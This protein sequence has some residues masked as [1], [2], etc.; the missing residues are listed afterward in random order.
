MPRHETRVIRDFLDASDLAALSALIAGVSQQRWQDG[1]QGTGYHKLS[2]RDEL[3]DELTPLAQRSLRALAV[4]VIDWDCYVLRYPAGSFIPLHR[5]PTDE[6]RHLRLNA[7]VQA[8]TGGQ[9]TIG[10]QAIELHRGDAVVFRPDAVDHAVAAGTGT[11]YV[12]SVGC[13]Y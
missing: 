3:G 12:W 7:I 9:L 11:R 10:G 6:H 5:D 13:V 2:L 8:S 1:R 4:D